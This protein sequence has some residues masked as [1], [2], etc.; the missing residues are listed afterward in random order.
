MLQQQ[1][2]SIKQ[3]TPAQL[4]IAFG[5]IDAILQLSQAT[6]TTR[7]ANFWVATS[8][9]ISA[10][11]DIPLENNHNNLAILQFFDPQGSYGVASKQSSIETIIED[12]QLALAQ[13]L[14]S[15]NR[16]GELPTFIWCS[17]SPGLEEGLIA[18]I[19]KVIGDN[20]PVFGG[21]AAD[22]DVSG[23]WCMFDGHQT[24]TTGFIIA[25]LFPSTPINYFFS[26]GY[27]TTEHKATVTCASGRKLH[28]LDNQPA[29]SVYNQWRAQK[30]LTPLMTGPVLTQSTFNPLGR[31]ILDNDE[32]MTLLSH[33]AFIYKDGTMELFSEVNQGEHLTFMHGNPALLIQRAQTVTHFATQQLHDLYD[34]KPLA[35]IVI[36][37]AGCM[38]A[39][40][41]ET[42]QVRQGIETVLNNVPFIGAFTFGEQGQ[43]AD[44]VNRHGNLMI[45]AV[46]FGHPNE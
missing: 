26:S 42:Y 14:S 33:P 37:C 41:D 34:S 9:C 40:K 15:A 21:T 27:E 29:A 6:E 23:K 24:I 43:F 20:V 2:S 5:N 44:G 22:N 36:F 39:I 1:I 8:S 3:D 31:V 30:M 11:S 38:L 19:R 16:S 7:V 17:Q 13:A 4:A 18:G 45:S 35:A 28:T 25:V 46:I 10:F 12:S 32:Q